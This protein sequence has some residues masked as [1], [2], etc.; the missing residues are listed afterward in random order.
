MAD[1]PPGW[2]VVVRV[3]AKPDE[4]YFAMVAD[5]AQAEE[6]VRDAAHVTG[7]G[8]VEAI[9]P[10]TA[11]EAAKHGLAPDKIIFAPKSMH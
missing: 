9:R 1:P 7:Q 8:S 4:H 5:K 10:L 6:Q 11:D 3:W 2:L